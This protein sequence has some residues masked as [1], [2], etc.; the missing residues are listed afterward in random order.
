MLFILD[1]SETVVGILNE[2]GDITRS[3]PFYDDKYVPNLDNGS[4]TYEFTTMANSP[5]GKFIEVGNYV[6]FMYK[7]KYKL[8]TIVEVT[9][10]HETTLLKTAYCECVGLELLNEVIR[11]VSIPSANIR[12]FMETV[13]GGT[14]F[15]LG[16]VDTSLTDVFTI[17]ISDYVNVYKAIQD[18]LSQYGAE[19]EFRFQIN[20]GRLTT[21][22]IDVYKERGNVTKKR[23]EYSK[24]IT[25]IQKSVDTSEIATALIGVGDNNLNFKTVAWSKASGDP[26]DKPLN[27]DFVADQDA[28]EKWGINGGHILGVYKMET[29]SPSELLLSTYKEL[30]IRKSPKIKYELD[31]ALL[32]EL[33]GIEDLNIGDTVYVV[34]HEFN[35]PLYLSARISKLEISFTNP[36]SNR[37]ILANFKEVKSNITTEVKIMAEKISQMPKAADIIN[38]KSQITPDAI[39]QTVKTELVD[40][41]EIDKVVTSVGQFDSSGLTVVQ[42]VGDTLSGS[43]N[44]NE[45]GL[46]LYDENGQQRASFGQNDAAYI[47]DLQ[48]ENIDAPSIIQKRKRSEPTA[49]YVAPVATGDGTGRD[50]SNK[51]NSIQTAFDNCFATGKYLDGQDISI[52]IA[53]G[54]YNEDLDISGILGTGNIYLYF[55]TNAKLVGAHTFSDN[56][57]YIRF[58]GAKTSITTNDGLQLINTGSSAAITLRK[59]TM[60][61]YGIRCDCKNNG[62]LVDMYKG[63]TCYVSTSDIVNAPFVGRL[64]TNSILGVYNCRGNVTTM[65]QLRE[66]STFI[67]EG[68]FPNY[69][70]SPNSV[71]SIYQNNTHTK[72]AS[73]YAP[74]T[75]VYT[76]LE[77]S[78][79]L[80]NYRSYK[81]SSLSSGEYN[82]ANWGSYTDYRGMADIP[83]S[84]KTWCTGGRNFTAWVTVKRKT[85]SHGYAGAVPTPR[86]KRPDGTFWNSGVAMARG[87]VK[88]IQLPADITNAI[89]AGTM[90][91]LEVYDT[92]Q[93]NYI[94][95]ETNVSIKVKC[96]K[97]V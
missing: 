82:Q 38:I 2:M 25:R 53:S 94:Q 10:T 27:Q 87:D 16:H 31:V 1:K 19:I 59:T 70:N 37:C 47:K 71:V 64:W 23:F 60:F 32:E 9:E 14:Q 28:F 61:I 73:L 83:S 95:F 77:N 78:F 29:S 17:E 75:A 89:V 86:F 45:E 93:D 21:R 68:N 52:N 55:D 97:L 33:T 46:I 41:G 12:Q 69:T 54:T 40:T 48:V 39:K 24:N 66:G 11:P 81:G 43:A 26:V 44:L 22:Y 90:S 74:P 4:E 62:G 49:W 65:A 34:D 92:S 56:I 91:V 84:L 50:T 20:K 6:A 42:Q 35:P 88:T 96:E 85:T 3:T 76:W 58:D 79:N 13:L 72:L 18:N 51:A 15:K 30:Q 5:Q 63:S 80:S 67:V 8:F 36:T 57:P 7:D